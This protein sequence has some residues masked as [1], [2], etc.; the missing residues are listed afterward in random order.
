MAAVPNPFSLLFQ[1]QS[2]VSLECGPAELSLPEREQTAE[3]IMLLFCPSP[4]LTRFSES[5]VLINVLALLL[6][7]D[8]R[9]YGELSMK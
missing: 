7:L 5:Y 8:E 4:G 9:I 3:T 1:T 2:L 6:I